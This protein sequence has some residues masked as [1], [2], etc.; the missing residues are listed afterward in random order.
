MSN[1][2]VLP[3]EVNS[4]RL[5]DGAGSGPL[6]VAAT[7][8]DGLAAEL[9]SA[10]SSFGS[11]TSGLAGSAWQGPASM[12]MTQAAASYAGWLNTAAS[13]AA[14]TAGQTRLAASSYESALAAAVHPM[15]IATN[16]TQLVSLV[17]SNFFGQNAAAI[18]ATEAHYEQMWAQDAAAMAS[19]HAGASAAV[20][21]LPPWL[22]APPNL[23]GLRTD[24]NPLASLVPAAMAHPAQF[25]P[26]PG[27]LPPFPPYPFPPYP[28]P[29]PPV[30]PLGILIDWLFDLAYWVV[31]LPFYVLYYSIDFVYSIIGFFLGFLGIPPIP[32]IPIPI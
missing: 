32:F 27:P 28:Y 30:S 19:Y 11:T 15:T 12:A 21:K 14:I 9:A 16:R 24:A 7:A 2:L 13:T 20:V 6:L 25:A 1:F 17:N 22:S 29:Y 10:A 31:T 4:A 26:P 3:P 23:L 8:W 18:A 5:Y